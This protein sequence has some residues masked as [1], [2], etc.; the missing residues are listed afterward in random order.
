MALMRRSRA[1]SDDVFPGFTEIVEIGAGSL[2]TV[3]RARE[4]GTDRYVA[5]KLLHVRDA[6]PRALESFERESVALGAVSSHANIVTLYRTFRTDDGRPVLVLELCRGSVAPRAQDGAGLPAARVVALGITI[7]GAL[8]TAHRAGILHGDVTPNNI[9]LTEFGQPALAD[10]GV[11]LLQSA[12]RTISGLRDGTAL[13]MAPELLEGRAASV[14]T[15]L[16]ELASTLYQLVAGHAAFRAHGGESPASVV[17]RALRDPV[18]PVAGPAVPSRLSELLLVA[19]SKDPQQ[20]LATAAD[21][22]AELAGIEIEQGWPRTPVPIRDP[23][24]PAPVSPAPVSPAPVSPAPV[25]QRPVTVDR[26]ALPPQPFRR[27]HAVPRS[28]GTPAAAGDAHGPGVTRPSGGPDDLATAA[29]ARSSRG[30]RG[31][32][33][34]TRTSRRGRP[35]R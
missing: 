11:A 33:R 29:A 7:A 20:R 8:E 26:A 1:A 18:Q 32:P 17:L 31:T 25:S 35:G 24:P 16:Y 6:S 10:F 23:R 22:A 15:D 4:L 13:H 9:L 14:A 34:R 12:T 3:Y 28:A 30:R 19:M 21:F 2:S 27:H 5:L